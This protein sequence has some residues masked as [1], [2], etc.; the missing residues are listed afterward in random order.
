LMR[1]NRG[2]DEALQILEGQV[3]TKKVRVGDQEE[4]VKEFKFKDPREL[5]L[6]AMG[7]I[8]GQLKLQ[9]EIFQALFDMRAVEEFQ[10][11]VLAAIGDASPDVR[12]AIIGKLNQRR[13]IRSTV[14]FS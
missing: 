4:F 8:R 5:A 3:S 6:K 14:K 11:E 13:A 1:W 2:D 7:E 9:L 12:S 10:Q